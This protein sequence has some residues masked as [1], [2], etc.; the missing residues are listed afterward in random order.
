MSDPQITISARRQRLVSELAE[1][2]RGRELLGFL[3]WRDICVRYRQTLLG[4]I[5][6]LLEP[7]VGVLIFTLLFNRMVGLT[8]GAAPYPLFCYAGM[9][10][11]ILF[12]RGLLAITL[13]L[14]S[15]AGLLTK[16]YFPRLA[17]PCASLLTAAVDFGCAFALFIV[18]ALYYRA[19]P[20]WALLTLPAWTALVALHALGVGLALAAINV[21]F[22]D[23]SRA[24]PFLTQT[25][26]LATP[27][28]YP[29]S[30]VPDRWLAWYRWN[31]MVGATEGLR[32]ALLPGYPLD[33][34]AVLASLLLAAIFLL[35]GLLCFRTYQR[36][37]ADIV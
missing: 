5:W 10:G 3:A 11:W 35:G 18:L 4:P 12:S 17:L 6:A 20:G 24:V 32:W 8:A 23:I 27:V 22:R 37:F 1:L 31:P 36:N 16:A 29:L 2:W 33:V 34:P 7:A 13:S 21:R 9:L 26:L 30:A 15:N 19:N 25:W 28:G 14:T